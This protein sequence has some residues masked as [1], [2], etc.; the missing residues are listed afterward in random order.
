MWMMLSSSRCWDRER[1]L[2]RLRTRHRG[3]RHHCAAQEVRRC[4]ETAESGGDCRPRRARS[5]SS[6]QSFS[7]G[8]Q[9]ASQEWMKTMRKRMIVDT[10]AGQRKISRPANGGIARLREDKRHTKLPWWLPSNVNNT[11]SLTWLRVE[12]LMGT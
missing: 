1:W 11:Y 10:A 3:L 5:R 2:E 12:Q 7:L 9:H 4:V 8:P 6:E